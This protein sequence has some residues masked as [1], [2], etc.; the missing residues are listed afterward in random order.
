MILPYPYLILR[1]LWIISNKNYDLKTHL[2]R[3]LYKDN[4]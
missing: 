4:S 2:L 3:L 1:I